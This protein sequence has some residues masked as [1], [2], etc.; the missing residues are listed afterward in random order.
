[1]IDFALVDP[2]HLNESLRHGAVGDGRILLEAHF[3]SVDH[4]SPSPGTSPGHIP[5]AI[6]VHPSYLEAGREETRYYPYYRRPEHGNLLPHPRLVRA[7]EALGITPRSEVIVYGSEPDGA[8]A[9]ARVIWGLIY[10]GVTRIRMLDGGL[11][12]WLAHGGATVP[13]IPG[14]LE[15]SA[16]L[17]RQQKRLHRWRERVDLRATTP[18][19]RRISDGAEGRAARLV[20]VRRAGEF[21]GTLTNC[22]PFF[23]KAGHI[24]GA[25]F[26]G[27]WDTLVDPETH[28]LAPCLE[29]VRRRWRRL[30]IVDEGVE[31]GV[32]S[33]VFYCGT[34]WRSSL[35][36]LVAL[37][38]G[39]RTQNYEDGF[40]G[41]SWDGRNR[42]AYGPPRT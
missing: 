33:L 18:E 24:P 2:E 34:G 16:P 9:A 26:H 28:R 30:N 1:M 38:L 31:S 7:I 12:A 39:Y 4:P 13:R 35:S 5:G 37:L 6:K 15:V 19:V 10:A 14:A 42:I 17:L 22:Y 29:A 40:Y 3:S 32:T 25:V 8:M 23:S 20:D 41:W 27:N 11:V 21:R 36:F